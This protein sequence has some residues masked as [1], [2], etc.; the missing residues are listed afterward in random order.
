VYIRILVQYSMEGWRQ[1]E[2][3]LWLLTGSPAPTARASP[4]GLR[5]PAGFG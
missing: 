1:P 4:E 2:N 5:S 3:P